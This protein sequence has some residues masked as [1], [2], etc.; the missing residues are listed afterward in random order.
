[1]AKVLIQIT[2]EDIRRGVPVSSENCPAA[3]ALRR[4]TKQPWH[5]GCTCICLLDD[6]GATIA[7]SIAQLPKK[8]IE[9]IDDVDCSNAVH[10]LWFEMEI[11]DVY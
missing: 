10:P 5:V 6:K 8:A 9:F 4:A 7:G 11:P 3:R 1:M 2:D